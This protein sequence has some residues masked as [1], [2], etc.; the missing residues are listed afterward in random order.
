MTNMTDLPPEVLQVVFSCLPLQT[1][2]TTCTRVCSQWRDIISQNKFLQWRKLYYRYKADSELTFQDVTD[3]AQPRPLELDHPALLLR[4]LKTKL[5]ENSA[6]LSCDMA[7]LLSFS[8][9]MFRTEK[10]SSLFNSIS[11]H[12][13]Y[14]VAV[15]S[16][17]SAGSPSSPVVVT[18]W[19]ILTSSDVW[20][21]RTI[22][23]L[24]LS[25]HSEATTADITEYLYM[26]AALLLY[27]ERVQ[28]LPPRFHYIVF[29]ALYFL[30]NDWAVTPEK[31]STPASVGAKK[32]SGQQSLMAF[33]FNKTVP[34]KLP[35]AEQLRIIQHPFSKER[36]DLIK[37]VAFAGT[38]KTTTLVRL[39]ENHPN[40]R[41]LVVVYNKSVRIKAEE[42]FPR[43]SSSTLLNI[44]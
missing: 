13:Q 42:Q 19:L 6:V 14:S 16:L 39:T 1:L 33:G 41:F 17:S 26:L 29:H 44:F 2:L 28:D 9:E 38:G 7:L 20:A 5:G 30:E 18:S 21:I 25:S 22:V 37:I 24:L 8:Q 43:Y 11:L 4:D 34:S 36:R 23:R 40:L 10:R 3:E 31:D 12:P 27:Y 32:A 35:T 15:E